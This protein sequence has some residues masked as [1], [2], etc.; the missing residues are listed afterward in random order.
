VLLFAQQ[1]TSG[2]GGE[3]DAPSCTFTTFHGALE[4]YRHQ[5]ADQAKATLEVAAFELRYRAY[6]DPGSMTTATRQLVKLHLS[7]LREEFFACQERLR[8]LE[9]EL[10]RLG[11]GQRVKKDGLRLQYMIAYKSLALARGRLELR[12]KEWEKWAGCRKPWMRSQEEIE[13]ILGV[14]Q[15]TASRYIAAVKGFMEP[16]MKK[17]LESCE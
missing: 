17:L 3:D 15:V 10:R 7:G 16:H 13:G 14:D 6:L 2:D 1:I 9:E 12:R 5:Q 8:A 11:R 4:A